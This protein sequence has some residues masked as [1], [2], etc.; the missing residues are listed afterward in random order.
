MCL[1]VL[2]TGKTKVGGAPRAHPER[3]PRDDLILDQFADLNGVAGLGGPGTL[4]TATS[5]P[6]R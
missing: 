3:T 6:A 5:S 2:G 4:T 1:M